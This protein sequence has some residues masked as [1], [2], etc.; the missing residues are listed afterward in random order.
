MAKQY[1]DKGEFKKNK[2][3]LYFWQ[4][5]HGVLPSPTPPK[6]K[7]PAP[8]SNIGTT[9]FQDGSTFFNNFYYSIATTPEK[10]SSQRTKKMPERKFK[11]GDIVETIIEVA[12][13]YL[14][15]GS[16]GEVRG[17]YGGYVAVAFPDNVE[18]SPGSFNIC[19]S[20]NGALTP[21]KD[22][23]WLSSNQLKLSERKPTVS[24]ESV[25]IADDKRQQILEALGQ[26]NNQ[27]LIFEDWGFAKTIEKGRGISMLFY[28]PP[29]TGK[30]L[31]AQA[32]AEKLGHKLKIIAAADIQSSEPGQ[33]ERNIREHFKGSVGKKTVLLFDECDSL[34]FDRTNVGAILGAQVNEL[35][36][37]L[38]KFE[39]ITIFTTNRLETLDDAVDRRLALKLEFAMPDQEQRAEIWKR[40]FPEECPLDDKVDFIKLA[41]VEIA[42]GHIKNAVLRA[43]RIAATQD[44]ADNEKKIT[45]SHL[46][47]SLQQEGKSMLAFRKAKESFNL[48]RPSGGGA[49]M[50]A[51]NRLHVDKV[52]RMVS[53]LTDKTEDASEQI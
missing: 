17:Y 52:Q 20:D 6:K 29:G 36:S 31:M 37:S 44:L 21:D 9:L 19:D 14:P 1:N 16:I 15:K 50:G 35:L 43:A 4:R 22:G 30:T 24:F 5:K 2:P 39:G 8:N 46:I 18:L 25:V 10:P 40:M 33:A 23:Y 42:G 28:G 32:I 26:I 27:K 49:Y 47:R 41:S 11:E 3:A 51:D 45:M 38:E 34:I 13:I 48:L 7:K 53:D 12:S